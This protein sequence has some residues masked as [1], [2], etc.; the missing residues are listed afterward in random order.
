[1]LLEEN[2]DQ[3]VGILTYHVVAGEVLSTDL[4]DGMMATTLQGTDIT[5]GTEGGVT[6][7]GANV[8]T[9]DIATSNG[10]IHV[11]DAVLLPA[12]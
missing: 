7:N 11:I 12:S 10:V 2:L 4:S 8:I 3:L 9:A 1:L 5:I 6:V